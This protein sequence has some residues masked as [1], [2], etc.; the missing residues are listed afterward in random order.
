[1]SIYLNIFGFKVPGYGLMITIGAIL[2]NLIVGWMVIKRDKKDILDLII[3]EAYGLLGGFL[4]A[5][6][7][8]IIVSFDMIEWDRLTDFNYLGTIIGGGFVFYGGLIGGLLCVII[9]GIAHKIDAWFFVRKYTFAIPFAHAFGRIGCFLAG[10][11]YGKPYDGPFAVVFPKGSI[12][13]AGISL[14]PV[15]LVEAICLMMIALV[16][17]IYSMKGG[18]K[19]SI[20]IYL[21]LYAVVRFV[22]EMFRYDEYRGKF[23]DL[24]T[25]QW[26][27]IGLFILGI[28]LIVVTKVVDK[29][30]KGNET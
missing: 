7:L 23:L 13:P 16:L 19:Y 12:A 4:G 11:C 9:A 3:I 15:Q 22:L 18:L 28:I 30:A 26:I 14:F 29:K 20:S 17:F 21:M 25:S 2:A 10:C 5:K 24:Y 1:M 6:I 27:S 8:Y